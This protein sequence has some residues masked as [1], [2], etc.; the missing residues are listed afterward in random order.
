MSTGLIA[1][2]RP[3]LYGSYKRPTLAPTPNQ[4]PTL[5]PAPAPELEPTPVSTPVSEPMPAPEL[6]TKGEWL[7]LGRGLKGRAISAGTKII[8]CKFATKTD[9]VVKLRD[10]QV[11]VYSIDQT[12]SIA[13]LEERK[14]VQQARK[15]HEL[16][17]CYVMQRMRAY[18]QA[19]RKQNPPAKRRWKFPE[20]AAKMYWQLRE[21]AVM[22]H[23][24]ECT[25]L[26]LIRDCKL[27]NNGYKRYLDALVGAGLVKH[28]F[29]QGKKSKFEL[30]FVK[31]A[32]TITLTNT[33][34]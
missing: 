30:V 1:G 20:P 12:N 33:T 26:D 29:V 15:F 5:D 14:A 4:Y 23:T 9:P 8:Q 32:P 21:R 6:H 17:Q 10:K 16:E 11:N 24:V 25:R 28:K 7:K 19:M 18:E 31:Q 3:S 27:D 13:E 2:T 34:K 22:T